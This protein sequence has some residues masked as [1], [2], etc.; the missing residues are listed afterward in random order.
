MRHPA[1][2]SNILGEHKPS[3]NLVKIILELTRNKPSLTELNRGLQRPSLE[4]EILTE[5][6]R[7]KPRLVKLSRGIKR[8]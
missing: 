2:L 8:C 1:K 3:I 4:T 6:S 5:F 7:V